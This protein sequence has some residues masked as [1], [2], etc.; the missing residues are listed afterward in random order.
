[1]AELEK[2]FAMIKPDAV[3]WGRA[4]EIMQLIQL[5]GFTIIAKQ[6][7]QVRWRPDRA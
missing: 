6:K 4:D 3:S 7:L 2:T 1:M 5:A